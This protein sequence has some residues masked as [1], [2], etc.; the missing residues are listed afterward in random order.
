MKIFIPENNLG[1]EA[2]TM[3]HMLRKRKDMRLYSEKQDRCGVRKDANTA[4]EFQYLANVKMRNDAILFD[5]EFYTSSKGHSAYSMKSLC[6]EELLRYRYEYQEGKNGKET[7][8]ITGKGGSG[9]NDDI[10]IVVC[11]ALKHGRDIL[12]SPRKM[13]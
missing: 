4:D 2:S 6:K 11:M 13:V 7:M 3:W 12:M 10:V 5:S 9:E 1:N 8:K